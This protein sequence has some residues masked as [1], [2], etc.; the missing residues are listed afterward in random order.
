M[1]GKT[2]QPARR[3]S[4]LAAAGHPAH[5]PDATPQAP[6]NG[7]EIAAGALNGA[8][9]GEREGTTQQPAQQ[10]AESAPAQQAAPAAAVAQP[11]AEPTPSPAPAVTA[12]PAA[13]APGQRTRVSLSAMLEAATNAPSIDPHVLKDRVDA[14]RR[15]GGALRS[16]LEN[17][18]EKHQGWL[19]AVEWARR[20]NVPENYVVAVAAEFGWE[21][22]PLTE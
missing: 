20:D 9:E 5:R 15:S 18:S 3:K 17:T 12:P 1:T 19:R 2:T 8:T 7:P 21:P 22:P 13:P 16:S 11:V 14:L 6:A 4:T 10:A